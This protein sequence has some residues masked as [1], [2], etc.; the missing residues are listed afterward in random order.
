[1]FYFPPP[2]QCHIFYS[3]KRDT[4]TVA[5][6]SEGAQ[7]ILKSR[8]RNNKTDGKDTEIMREDGI[9]DMERDGDVVSLGVSS[10]VQRG[11]LVS[12]GAS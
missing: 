8:R 4:G 6:F 12:A 3:K 5:W 11:P 9:S 2:P 7:N 1:M 10:T